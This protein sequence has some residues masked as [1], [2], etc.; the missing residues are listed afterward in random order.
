[1]QDLNTHGVDKEIPWLNFRPT[2]LV[3]GCPPYDEVYIVNPE[4]IDRV[5]NFNGIDSGYDTD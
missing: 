4:L 5:R 1:M 2:I 3:K